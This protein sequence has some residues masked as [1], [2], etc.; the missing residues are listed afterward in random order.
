[1]GAV[2]GGDDP[3]RVEDGSA[4]EWFMGA[5]P[6]ETNLPG[7]LVHLRSAP[8]H[9]ANPTIYSAASCV[10]QEGEREREKNIV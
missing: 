3:V 8:T 7:V 10:N 4:T 6:E 9:N 1:M 5:P 2:G